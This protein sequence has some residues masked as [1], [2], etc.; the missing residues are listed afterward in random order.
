MTLSIE[1]T[2]ASYNLFHCT[3]GHAKPIVVTMGVSGEE[4]AMKVETGASVS[5]ISEATYNKL[6]SKD[7]AP[8]LQPSRVNI[9]TYTGEQLSI[10]GVSEVTALAV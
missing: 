4:I 10:L 1:R 6:W 3:D 2:G 8:P 5:I 7:Q 9:E